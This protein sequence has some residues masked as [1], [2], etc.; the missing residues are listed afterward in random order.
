MSAPPAPASPPAFHFRASRQP[1]L[2]AAL[3]YSVGIVAG[4]YA[5]RP[6]LWW[7]VAVACFIA[8]AAY[9]SN[10]RPGL[11]WI[12]ALAAFFLGGALHIQVRSGANRMDTAIQHYAGQPDLQITAH[13]IKDARL[14]EDFDEIRQSLDVETEEVRTAA[15][16]TF[17]MHSGIRLSIYSPR[18]SR[19][20]G[21]S[22]FVRPLHY[23]ERIRFSGKLRV[24]RNFRNPGAFDYRGYLGDHGIAA[25]GSA[26]LEDVELLPG[27]SGNWLESWRRRLHRGVITKV[28]ALW[29][30]RDA[31]LLDAMV[32]GEEAFVDRD[33][34]VDF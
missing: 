18:P 1:M 14:Q 11:G 25:L 34:R 2:W 16:Q 13:V 30:T 33:T 17:K 5:W 26:K 28:H 20:L 24:P 22:E 10:R 31:A 4:A 21:D 27:F 9:F 3:A 12:V 8:A 6:A 23:G 32:I 19:A 29:P 15:G 7:A